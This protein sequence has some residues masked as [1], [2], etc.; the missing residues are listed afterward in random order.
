MGIPKAKYKLD[1]F[2]L[3]DGLKRI[4]PL[5]TKERSEELAK[6]I[7]KGRDEITVHDLIEALEGLSD[8][9]TEMES[10]ES[11]NIVKQKIKIA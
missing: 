6:T 2:K 8:G 3:K 5:M 7:L 11:N 4:D 10:I 9:A 1:F